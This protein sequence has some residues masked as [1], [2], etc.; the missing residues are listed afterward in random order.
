LTFD[1]NLKRASDAVDRWPDW[2]LDTWALNERNS[3]RSKGEVLPKPEPFQLPNGM[4][5][6][7][8]RRMANFIGSSPLE[9]ALDLER[10]LRRWADEI[11]ACRE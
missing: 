4:S 7:T 3:R 11:E 5:P 9:G 8:L 1:E 2:M 10:Q 6:T